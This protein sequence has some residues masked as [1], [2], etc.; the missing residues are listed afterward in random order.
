MFFPVETEAVVSL[1]FC[2]VLVYVWL[3]DRISQTINE[4]KLTHG[5]ESIVVELSN[6][7]ARVAV[8]EILV[9]HLG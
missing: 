3:V 2:E 6:E 8:F 7:R 9:Q 1:N 5:F 4:Y